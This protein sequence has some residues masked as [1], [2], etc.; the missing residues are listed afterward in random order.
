MNK[1]RLVL[2]L[3]AI[4]FSGINYTAPSSY[5]ASMIAGE[6]LPIIVKSKNKLRSGISSI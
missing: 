6:A 5:S 2:A 4:A 1:K 3:M